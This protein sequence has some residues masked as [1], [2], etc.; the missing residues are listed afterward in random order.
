MCRLFGLHAGPREIAATFWLVEAPDSLEEQSHRN[1]D[2][3]GIGTFREEETPV[4]DKAPLSAW[5]DPEFAK[6]AHQLMGTTFVAH[7]RKASTGA[8]VQAN[9]HPFLQRNRLF[10][11]N[12][13]VL[14]LDRL[15]ARLQELGV[16][17]LVLGDTDSERIFALITAEVARNNDDV[18]AGLQSAIAWIAE[19]LPVYALNFVLTTATDVW[20][21]RYPATHRLFVLPRPPGG[22]DTDRHLQ[23]RGSLMDAHS[24]QLATQASVIVASEEMDD[25][26]QW[27]L[28]EPGE[29]L[30]VDAELTICSSR[31]FPPPRHLVKR[32]ELDPVAAAS[33]DA[34]G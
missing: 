1:P 16:D 27:R 18:D 30:H 29:L 26:S 33:Q 34:E 22:T 3:F 20:A 12:G 32:S 24:E 2:G 13:V 21:L 10:A 25:D 5:A 9:T 17:R 4:V 8:L 7:V 28:L 6:A 19:E 15:D 31:P 11:H 14:G 23:T